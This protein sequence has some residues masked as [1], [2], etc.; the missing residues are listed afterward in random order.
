MKKRTYYKN[1]ILKDPKLPFFIQVTSG[2][3]VYVTCLN[4]SIKKPEALMKTGKNHLIIHQDNFIITLT[5]WNKE[6]E[7]FIYTIKEKKENEC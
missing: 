6:E 3:S 5:G 2:L 1:R 4:G 7:K